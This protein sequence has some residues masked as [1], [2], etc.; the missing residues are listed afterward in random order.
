MKKK[1]NYLVE[2]LIAVFAAV[3]ISLLLVIVAA[4]I[5]KLCNIGDGAI[6]V[7]NQII[8]GISILLACLVCLRLP[9][10]G[11]IRGFIVGTVYIA[12]AFVIFSLL[13]GEFVFDLSLLNDCVLG[14]VSGLISGIIAVNIR[15]HED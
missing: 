8:K 2:T 5:I 1:G 9:S 7:I 3:V 13:S 15:R 12:L 11:W 10:N 6:M 14:G 4:F